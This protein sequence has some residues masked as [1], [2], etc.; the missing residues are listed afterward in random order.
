MHWC[1]TNLSRTCPFHDNGYRTSC[2][3]WDRSYQQCVDIPT[4]VG[5]DPMACRLLNGSAVLY[6]GDSLSRQHFKTHACHICAFAPSCKYTTHTLPGPPLP[7]VRA[8]SSITCYHFSAC[9]EICHLMAST[10]RPA[11]PPIDSAIRYVLSSPL[12]RQRWQ[13]LVLIANAGHWWTQAVGEALALAGVSAYRHER[14]ANASKRSCLIWRETSPSDFNTSDGTY[15]SNVT[16]FEATLT[17]RPGPYET[18]WSQLHSAIEGQA[19]PVLHVHNLSR[20]YWQQHVDTRC[21]KLSRERGVTRHDCLHYCT[22]GP[23]DLWI[24]PMTQLI[25][26]RCADIASPTGI[27]KRPRRREL[28]ARAAQL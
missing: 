25:S 20:S 26:K 12:F 10:A 27:S 13:R 7:G 11:E 19:V 28:H 24:E 15:P 6:I 8:S 4:P 1:Q 18:R 5:D 3:L 17:C 16:G 9:F 21:R 2:H 22:P 23:I 14:H